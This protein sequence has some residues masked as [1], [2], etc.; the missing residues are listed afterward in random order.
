[1]RLPSSRRAWSRPDAGFGLGHDVQ[2]YSEDAD[3]DDGQQQ[4]PEP[5]TP[6]GPGSLTPRST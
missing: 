4:V 2:D 6:K 3:S 5:Q 1:M